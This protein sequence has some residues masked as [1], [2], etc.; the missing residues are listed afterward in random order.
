MYFLTNGFVSLGALFYLP[1]PA[2]AALLPAAWPG[3]SDLCLG[4]LACALIVGIDLIHSRRLFEADA[5]HMYLATPQTAEERAWWVGHSAAAGITEELT[6]RGVQPALIAQ[7]T[8][9]PWLALVI[10]R[11]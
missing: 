6:W 4:A 11:S 1:R 9:Q 7:W 2:R 3:F 5:P 8:G 10:W